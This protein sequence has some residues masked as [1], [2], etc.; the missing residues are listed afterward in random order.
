MLM[1][2]VLRVC[3]LCWTWHRTV[4]SVLRSWLTVD[5]DHSVTVFSVSRSVCLQRTVVPILR[6]WLTVDLTSQ[7]YCLLCVYVLG[8]CVYVLG[9]CHILGLTL[10]CVVF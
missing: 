4:L 3:A 2:V 7:C 5:L 8:L 10:Y 6:S 1:F 9:L